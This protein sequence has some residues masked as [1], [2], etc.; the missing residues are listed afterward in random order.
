MA[1]YH[2]IRQLLPPALALLLSLGILLLNK[3]GLTSLRHPAVVTLILVL[4]AACWFLF[5]PRSPARKSERPR[6]R[7]WRAI[8]PLVAFLAGPTTVTAFWALTVYVLEKEQYISFQER[9]EPLMA[10]MPVGVCGGMVAGVV[11]T[12]WIAFS[13]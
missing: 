9:I 11:L 13:D 5:R 1:R 2:L 8:A 12:V 3:D 6:P 10:A 4:A 7:I